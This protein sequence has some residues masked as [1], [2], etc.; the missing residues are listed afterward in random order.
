[1]KDDEFLIAKKW[2]LIPFCVN[3]SIGVLYCGKS[4]FNVFLKEDHILQR[5]MGPFGDRTVIIQT[6]IYC[7]IPENHVLMTSA[8]YHNL[9]Y[10][11]VADKYTSENNEREIILTIIIDDFLNHEKTFLKREF[12]VAMLTLY[13]LK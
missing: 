3:H 5:T 11:V 10:Y 13:G 9:G 2:T 12:P 7:S 4:Y 1:M 6:G 8:K